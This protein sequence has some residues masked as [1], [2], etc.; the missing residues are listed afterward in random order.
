ME[1]QAE[2]CAIRS[3][4]DLNSWIPMRRGLN[5]RNVVWKITVPEP[6]GVGLGRFDFGSWLPVV[7]LKKCNPEGSPNQRLE[8]SLVFSLDIILKMDSQYRH[9]MK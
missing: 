7:S 1:L 5:W 9:G 4:F 6:P 3:S 2:D 8:T